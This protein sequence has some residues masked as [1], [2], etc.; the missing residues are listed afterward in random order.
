M[1]GE[2]TGEDTGEEQAFFPLADEQTSFLVYK[3][4][5]Y[6]EVATLLK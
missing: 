4:A 6:K 3:R 1:A 5:V 2:D